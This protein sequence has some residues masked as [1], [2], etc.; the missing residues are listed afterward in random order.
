MSDNLSKLAE[1]EKEQKNIQ[2]K[3]KALKRK[4]SLE[5]ATDSA[6]STKE[7]FELWIKYG[8]KKD[9]DMLHIKSK[10]GLD[11]MQTIFF[12][13]KHETFEIDIIEEVL[14]FILEETS[15]SPDDR[16]YNER[17]TEQDIFDWMVELMEK[18]VGS[19]SWSW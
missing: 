16:Q 17:I 9:Y 18:E 6:L 11:M 14:L 12:P 5:Y 1:L 19:I 2:K 15:K 4:I 3:I 8:V 7:R 13:D 10:S